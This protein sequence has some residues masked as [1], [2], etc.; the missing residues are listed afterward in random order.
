MNF[1]TVNTKKISAA[2]QAKKSSNTGT[3]EIYE[4]GP[5]NEIVQS[6]KGKKSSK[7]PNYYSFWRKSGGKREDLD[8]MTGSFPIQPF[9]YSLLNGSQRLVLNKST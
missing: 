3:I 4:P 8:K 5:E 1:F 7:I 2:I 9:S 6:P